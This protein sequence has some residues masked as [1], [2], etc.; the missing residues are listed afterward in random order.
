MTRVERMSEQFA[1]LHLDVGRFALTLHHFT[2]PDAGDPHDHPYPFT[3]T[4]LAG[5]YVEEVWRRGKD[6][7]ESRRV[8]RE[9]GTTHRVGARTIHRIVELPEGE[10]VTAV[11]WHTEGVARR[12]PRFYRLRGGV[13]QSRRWNE[14]RFK[15]RARPKRAR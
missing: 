15:A 10:C 4:I 7:W 9:P 6:G 1:K 2:G 13:M 8:H 11:V 3:T 5:G 12:E 14:P